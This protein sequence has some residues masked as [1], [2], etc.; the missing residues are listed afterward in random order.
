MLNAFLMLASEAHEEP[1]KTLF[2][3]FGGL[4]A[5]YAVGLG[6]YALSRADWPADDNTERGVMALSAVLVLATLVSAIATG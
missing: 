5:V 1:D 4:L 6:A 3:V 2:Y